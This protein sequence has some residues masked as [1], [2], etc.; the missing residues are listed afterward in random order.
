MFKSNYLDIL[1]QAHSVF[2]DGCYRLLQMFTYYKKIKLALARVLQPDALP[3][4]NRSCKHRFNQ[5]SPVQ[6][7]P[8]TLRIF[9][10]TLSS[11]PVAFKVLVSALT[12]NGNLNAEGGREGKEGG[13]EGRK[14]GGKEGGREGGK[15]GGRE[16]GW[17]LRR[18]GREVCR[19]GG[20]EGMRERMRGGNEGRG[21]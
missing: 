19:E 14:E 4:V 13:R 21:R 18:D 2:V 8:Q 20:R 3:D 12:E 9:A 16:G 1:F 7:V 10:H 11:C 17:V 6:R 5:Q 15:E